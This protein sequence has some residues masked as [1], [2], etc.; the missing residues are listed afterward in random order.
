MEVN[1]TDT[2]ATYEFGLTLRGPSGAVLTA[3]AD[4]AGGARLH[5]DAP[6]LQVVD[7]ARHPVRGLLELAEPIEAVGAGGGL[8]E[9]AVPHVDQALALRRPRITRGRDGVLEGG[10]GRLAHAEEVHLVQ[11]G[12]RVRLVVDHQHGALAEARRDGVPDATSVLFE[13]AQAQ[14]SP[15]AVVV[16]HHALEAPHSAHCSPSCTPPQTVC[17]T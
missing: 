13:P 15:P 11:L 3:L 4:A 6:L 10:E 16:A 2:D 9:G 17:V 1:L 7:Q 14:G 8:G 12:I 5:L